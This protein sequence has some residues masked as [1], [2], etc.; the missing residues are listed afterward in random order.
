MCFFDRVS[1]SWWEHGNRSVASTVNSQ[2]TEARLRSDL[3]GF[4]GKD[5]F[6]R[7]P[8]WAPVEAPWGWGVGC[9]HGHAQMDAEP[10]RW[11][12][13]QASGHFQ[14]PELPAP[15]D[16]STSRSTSCY[17]MG[18]KEKW[19]KMGEKG[20]MWGKMGKRGGMCNRQV[21]KIVP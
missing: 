10:R 17:K 2:S 15:P 13:V 3:S 16:M 21:G 6:C 12:S 20:V 14:G 7:A 8:S 1:A 19:G 18:K 11:T 4:R 5:P 9:G